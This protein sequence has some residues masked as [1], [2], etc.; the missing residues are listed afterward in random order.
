M[1][2]FERDFRRARDNVRHAV[3]RY[4][5]VGRVRGDIDA[6]KAQQY[7]SD[8]EALLAERGRLDNSHSMMDGTLE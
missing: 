8:Q 5:L 2:D 1:S 7:S 4:E 3:D 6:Y